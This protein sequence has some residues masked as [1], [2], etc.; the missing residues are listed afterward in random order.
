[1]VKRKTHHVLGTAHLGTYVC[2]THIHAKKEDAE[3]VDCNREAHNT[4]QHVCP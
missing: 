3:V 2:R 4:Q 1:M